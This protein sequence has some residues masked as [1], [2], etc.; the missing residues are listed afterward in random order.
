MVD[1]KDCM[2]KIA[3]S[4]KSL[5]NSNYLDPGAEVSAKAKMIYKAATTPG[6]MRKID[7]Y[8]RNAYLSALPTHVLNVLSNTVNIGFQPFVTLG[9]SFFSKNVEAADSLR[10]I[11]GFALGSMKALPRFYKNFSETLQAGG[12]GYMPETGK[13]AE[14]LGGGKVSDNI[15]LNRAFTL[16]I[17]ATKALDEGSKAVLEAMGAEVTKARLLADPRLLAFAKKQGINDYDLNK[18]VGDFLRGEESPLDILAKTADFGKYI[19]EIE[20]W[21]DFNTYNS[22]LGDSMID[23]VTKKVEGVREALPGIGSFILPFIKIP[24]NVAKE[25]ASYVP[26]LGELRVRQAKLDTAKA[27]EKIAETKTKLTEA[28]LLLNRQLKQEGSE[29]LASATKARINKLNEQLVKLNGAKEFYEKL[30]GRFRAQQLIGAGIGATTYS[31]AMSGVIT[32]HFNDP[33]VR[34]T[35]KAAGIP[36]MSVKIGDR[37]VNYG[38]IEP[39]STVMGLVADTA[40][41]HKDM[42]KEGK[43]FIDPKLAEVAP[44]IF[45]QNFLDKTF[46]AALSDML[47]AIQDPARYGSWYA[48]LAGGVVPAAVGQAARLQDPTQRE[49]K[50]GLASVANVIQSRIPDVGLGLPSRRDLPPSVDVLGQESQTANSVVEGLLG[51]TPLTPLVEA[52]VGIEPVK[53]T[54]VQKLLMN[55]YFK[56]GQMT[57]DLFGIELTP[58]EL[59]GLRSNAGKQIVEE[60][61][62]QLQDPDFLQASKPSQA[63]RI[64]RIFTKIRGGARKELLQEI[65]EN[66]PEREAEL[67]MKKMTAKGEQ[68][69]T[70]F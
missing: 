35:M 12:I 45:Y 49:T 7:A 20:M 4:L 39:F 15:W 3:G 1:F 25:G 21:S 57:K 28:K 67:D 56:V 29:G 22:P 59:S 51:K 24:V 52:A 69:D 44:K 40:Q 55:P 46:T 37:W 23:R 47:M 19:R 5:T 33:Q 53:Q 42:L 32:G 70:S 27:V 38:R 48:N 60:L 36:E 13:A 58:A 8:V 16:P 6:F 10:M 63:F 30:P 68:E 11:K 43:S 64:K 17:A 66:S 65:I 34:A 41:Y 18:Y 26:G 2:Q 14:Y 9:Q 50:E 31:L 61:Y 54:E 62:E